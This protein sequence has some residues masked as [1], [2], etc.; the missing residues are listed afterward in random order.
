VLV[1]VIG[2]IINMMGVHLWANVNFW[3]QAKIIFLQA[4]IFLFSISAGIAAAEYL[5]SF[6][7]DTDFLIYKLFASVTSTVIFLLGYTLMSVFLLK[8]VKSELY[9]AWNHFLTNRRQKQN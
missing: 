4:A 3:K 7:L 2:V 5:P 1:G 9:K 6:D 8:G